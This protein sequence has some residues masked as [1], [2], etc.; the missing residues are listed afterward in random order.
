MMTSLKIIDSK[1]ID[2]SAFGFYVFVLSD[3]QNEL[4]FVLRIQ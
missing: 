1:V 4:V 2:G 3:L